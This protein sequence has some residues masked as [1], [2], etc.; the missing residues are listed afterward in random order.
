MIWNM[1]LP[2]GQPGRGR[3][4]GGEA[5]DQLNLTSQEVNIIGDEGHV[6]LQLHARM[7]AAFQENVPLT[8]RRKGSLPSWA[9]SEESSDQ[10]LAEMDGRT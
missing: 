10:P 4:R 5:G 1:S 2:A 3:G 8:C 9:G 6:V 7:P